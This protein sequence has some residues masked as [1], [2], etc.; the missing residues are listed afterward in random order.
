M[1]IV[2]YIIA[3][4]LLVCSLASFVNLKILSGF[5][6]LALAIILLPV[7]S[8]KIKDKLE[9]WKYRGVRYVAYLF[10]FFLGILCLPNYDFSNV[11]KKLSQKDKET[12]E[13]TEK[14]RLPYQDYLDQTGKNI[15][16]L[17][18]E[19]KGFRKK[20]LSEIQSRISKISD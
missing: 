18:Q 8:Q 19:R 20:L 9:V 11:T 3:V 4:L 2:K 6:F 7:I 13:E 14:A 10:L 15:A 17:S 5:L 1:K 12:K 16:G